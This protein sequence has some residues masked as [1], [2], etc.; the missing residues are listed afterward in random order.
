MSSPKRAL[1]LAAA[2]L[3]TAITANAAL[4]AWL[5]HIVGA[6][7]MEA[8]LYRT[9]HLPQADVLYPRPPKEAQAE[10]ARDISS[11]PDQAELYQLR[12]RSDEAA[13]DLTAAEDDWKEY[14]TRSKDSL[15][16]K[17]ELANFYRR[18]LATAKEL[19]VLREVATA[20]N[21]DSE[22]YL[23]PARQ[24]SWLA[25]QRSLDLIALQGLPQSETA[26]TYDAFL[27]RYPTQPAVYTRAFQ[28]ALD[29]EDYAA[30][31][32]LIPRY[33]QA[34]PQDA[35]FPVRA[36]ALLEYSR[37]DIDRA[38][39]VYEQ[40]YQPLWPA[41]LVK[42][43]FALLEQTH[44]QRAFVAD[45][46]ARLAAKPDG[47]AALNALTRVFYYDQQ[48]GRLLQ[49]QQTL[50]AF[51]TAREQRN[52]AWSAEDLYT[53]TTLERETGNYAEAA[54]YNFALASTP[55]NLPSGEPAAQAGLAALTDI[56]LTAP[57]QP[58]ALGAGNLTIYRDIA[59]LDQGP[60]YWNGIL[61][62]WL[63]GT[64]PAG[65]YQSETGKAQSYFHRA[66]A[67]E[68]LAQLDA[69]FPNA[70]ERAALHAQLIHALT[71]YGEPQATID[72]GKRFLADFP[73]S[74]A[75]IEIGGLIA[76][77][78]AR[79]ND[80][81]SEFK[82][83]EQLLDELAAK[84]DGM[85]LSAAGAGTAP[86]STDDPQ[87][88]ANQ[89]VKPASQAFA[90]DTTTTI[91][92]TS[93][94]AQQY[95]QL[96]DRYIA[97]LTA[98]HQLPQ[99]LL[100]LRHQ[101]D[102]NAADPALY[103]KLATFLQQNNLTGEQEQLYKQAA[104]R[105]Q[106]PTWYDKLARFYLRQRNQQAFATL[107]RQVTDIFSG[108]DLEPYF[109]RV[110]ELNAD[111]QGGAA[112]AVQ[113]N[114][115][116]AKRFPHDLVFT[117]NLLSAYQSKPTLNPAA[118]DALL[119]QTWWE[120]DDLR[121][122][123]FASLSESGKL[124]AELA[125]LTL[126]EQN[127]AAV[128]ESAEVDL[129]SSHFEDAAK[130]LSAL[131]TL[132]PADPDLDD[133]AVSLMRSLAYLD[134]TP[135]FLNRAVEIE[136]NLLHAF[137]DS[138]ERLATLG[139]LYAE[140]TSTAGE[141]LLHAEPYWRR[142]PELHRGSPAGTLAAATIFWDYFQYDD[143][144][145]LLKSARQRFQQPTLYGYE[146]GA[147]EE[148][149]RDTSAAIREYTAVVVTPPAH[150]FFLTSV[151]AAV[152]AYEKPPSDAADSNL[153]ST[154]QSVF[155][156]TEARERLLVLAARPATAKLV[157]AA[158]AAYTDST[159]GLTLRADVLLAQHRA[160]ELPPLLNA[161]L[162]RAT[163]VEQAAAIGDLAHTNATQ[164]E[165][166]ANL[167]EVDVRLANGA[168]TQ[169]YAAAKTYA[170]TSVY[171]AALARQA[172]LSTDPVSRLEFQYQLA[173]AYEQR[174]DQ[175]DA[176]K[177]YLSIYQANPRLLG[178]V[179]ATVD[180]DLRAAQP[181]QAIATLLDAAKAATPTLARSFT[182]EAAAKANDSGNFAQG[183]S[184]A[185]SQLTATPYDPQVLGLV[186]ASYARANDNAGLKSFYLAQLDNVKT[187][188]LTN[189]ERK[190]NTALLRRGLIPALTTLKDCEG[191]T[192]QYI[193]LLSA[194]PED[195]GT[196]QEAALYALRYHR[197]PQ[198]L[199]FLE[200]TV[201]QS[202][203]DS[204]FAILLAQTVTTFEDLPAA[205]TA[206]DQAI[207]IRKD[208]ADLYQ[209][210]AALDLR[211]GRTDPAAADYERLYLL[212]YKDPQ[213]LVRLAELRVRQQR[214]ADAVK[215]LQAAY[216]E[217]RPASA[218]NQFT[219]AAQ[220]LQWNL[221]AEA[222]TFADAGRNLAG[223]ALLTTAGSTNVATYARI[224]TRQGLAIEASNIL[225]TLR[226]AA[227]AAPISNA[228]MLAELTKQ[229][230]TEEDAAD[231]RKTFA[232]QRHATIKANYDSAILAIGSTI[233]EYYTPE[234]KLAY[235]Q[236]LDTLHLTNAPQAIAAAAAAHLTDREATWRKQQLLTRPIATQEDNLAAYT[237]LQ[238]S[239]LAFVDLAQT[240]ELYAA[241]L[242]PEA[243]T[244][245]RQQAAQ[246][247]HDA[248]TP[249]ALAHEIKLAHQLALASD[250]GVR[251]HFLDLLLHHDA[252]AFDTL[253]AS[254]DATLADA[255]VNYAVAHGTAGQANKA[256]SAR[257]RILSKTQWW[258]AA[259]TA[260]A[261]LYLAP[262]EASTPA[263]FFLILNPPMTI[264]ERLAHLE[265]TPTLKGDV[266]FGFA[267]RYGIAQ[268]AAKNASEAEDS[269][270]ALLEQAPTLPA[271]Y[272]DLARTYAEAGNT[273]AALA[274][275]AHAFE[276]APN[277]P[278][279][280]DEIAILQ[281]HAGN[282]AAALAEWRLTL[283][284]LRRDV[285]RNNF[286]EAFYSTFKTTLDH[287]G[288]AKL[289]V[290]L[291]AE[292]DAVLKPELAKNGNYR[293]N[294]LLEAIYQSAATTEQGAAQILALSA[295][296]ANP[297]QV[298]EDLY[299]AA[300]V[301]PQSQQ[302]FLA[303]RL[304]LAAAEDSSA[305][306]ADVQ[307][308]YSN[309]RGQLL[310]SY[311]NQG[312]TAQA[313]AL[314]DAIPATQ[315]T[316][317]GIQSQH[318]RLAAR[319]GRLPALLAAYTAAP[320]TAPALE[321]LS[322][323]ANTLAVTD[324]TSALQLRQYVFDQKQLANA[325]VPA[326]F[327]SLAQ[328]LL[329]VNDVPAAAQ[330]LNRLALQPSST[331]DPNANLD[332]AAALLESTRH[333]TEAAPLLKSLDATAPWNATYRLRLA[334]ATAN[335]AAFAAI[336]RDPSAPYQTRADAALAL[337]TPAQDLGSGE[338]NL[339]ATPHPV[340]EA[341]RQPYFV[342]SRL[343]AAQGTNRDL[344]REAVAIAPDGIQAD[345]ARLAL[346]QLAA[347][348]ANPAPALALLSNLNRQPSSVADTDAYQDAEAA[349]EPSIP[350]ASDPTAVTLPAMAATLD[351]PTRVRLA[352]Q[353][354][355][356][357]S[358]EHDLDSALAWLLAARKL[359]PADLS[360][361]SRI[362]QARLAR[363]LAAV[364]AA[365]RPVLGPEL[366]SPI[367]VR[368]RLTLAQLHTRETP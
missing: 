38:L 180:Y 7:S 116:A 291:Q 131:A 187:A 32:A 253:A 214:N 123:F 368:P 184:L 259:S 229:G 88:A 194:Y 145:A 144:L 156:A 211:L 222:R 92:A 333:D 198:L 185:Q 342:Q 17:L 108:T 297:G 321:L 289:T 70:P 351:L 280:H 77:A 270:P 251:D 45:G 47:P 356:A 249:D 226:R 9:M 172:A 119:R 94:D 137:P 346:L 318:L 22:R 189:E 359:S 143:A 174:N 230:L 202:P 296:A 309:L 301:S 204:R 161:A 283:D 79:Q 292:I 147:I 345:R 278:L 136:T 35:A 323:T 65:E 66:K 197:Q 358:R 268:L 23:D 95:S 192:N 272:V 46:R 76:D 252:A 209:A 155:N 158:T 347:L 167:H 181:R 64:S 256:I 335:A 293:S 24:R 360:L 41:D 44:H 316:L 37:G 162:A 364:N 139:D 97:R 199:G 317:P 138:P 83:Y 255:A 262:T 264:E 267:S 109:A 121:R 190:A 75:R 310:E 258:E 51:R 232:E 61:S 246:A 43:Y 352:E 36:Q 319:T 213:W 93:V 165:S 117:R 299:K 290:S 212:S 142:I 327:L 218:Q 349:D 80:T 99:A 59:M 237:H 33:K 112:L 68:L 282:P 355:A 302:T 265:P 120:A 175:A 274:E 126:N 69:K 55:G 54:R 29:A 208:R 96:L 151:D 244:E 186:A 286:S 266:W 134:V 210:R 241:R 48:A 235:A 157:D 338:L 1:G 18:Q 343:V 250:A 84:T 78:Y 348:D 354:G 34:F 118:H 341:I 14:A 127:P 26:A 304:Q 314:F 166:E 219:V 98:A 261:G 148:N 28:S 31:Q 177:L 149:R 234:Q 294:E 87:P 42:S 113:L 2:L 170:L 20:P 72:A 3:A 340:A 254:S 188:A 52:A 207:A 337:A 366:R 273:P 159:A 329:A 240:L 154:V 13:L 102:R 58:L 160:A 315:Q 16:A 169:S 217:G 277:Q 200:T 163:T 150:K 63:N 11:S 242:A 91:A 100:V 247:W 353:L 27:T 228:S 171:E 107:T 57:E 233:D 128:R 21:P 357:Y 133:R 325:L 245:P 105:F 203:R 239:R 330:L 182:L 103:E 324:K 320:T 81:S 334:R 303:R 331:T 176:G 6:S 146:A 298:L 350:D 135:A 263:A 12:A 221:I 193:A 308:D 196:A 89:T 178:V 130:P 62:L 238:Q 313:Q 285:L 25:F 4:P 215:A 344:L 243:R 284:L 276:L 74:S 328:S 287:L 85:P 311:L 153:Q 82:L 288:Q 71:Q 248:G 124:Q 305:T 125:A 173:A 365:R 275:Y 53:L 106:Q 19:A 260:V 183:R 205:I 140:A 295:S 39:A 206:Y 306:S 141:D 361:D 339:L 40:A 231:F 56:L 49:A 225:T 101:L 129:W 164:P 191:A 90:L 50:D 269:L 281:S 86:T 168:T 5:Q 30:A 115:Y 10:L 220:L 223:T 236:T 111:E 367:N 322:T 114:L 179:R 201:K 60:G 271:P 8:A 300:W 195:A 104:A 336:A 279:L 257:G 224:L 15:A 132:Y 307:S 326:D 216:I 362:A 122:Q 152:S 67:A 312:Q 73:K 332:S 110:R 227:D 363:R